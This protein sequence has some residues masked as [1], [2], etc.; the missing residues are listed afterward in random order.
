MSVLKPCDVTDIIAITI[1]LTLRAVA[2]VKNLSAKNPIKLA[3]WHS[4]LKMQ[5][6][7]KLI[8]G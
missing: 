8:I 2:S 6:N 7:Q 5:G 1:T 3:Y 4:I